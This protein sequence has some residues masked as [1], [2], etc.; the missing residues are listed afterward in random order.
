MVMLT[1]LL[2]HKR[3]AEAQMTRPDVTH[4][5]CNDPIE[6]NVTQTTSYIV[7]TPLPVLKRGLPPPACCSTSWSGAAVTFVWNCLC[8]HIFT[9]RRSA[10]TQ[11]RR[12]DE[13]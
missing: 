7:Q 2:M 8:R 9:V 1:F 5:H 13:N 3:G 6:S 10:N 11:K 12:S 4:G